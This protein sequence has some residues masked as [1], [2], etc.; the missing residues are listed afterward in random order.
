[1]INGGD[2]LSAISIA[3]MRPVRNLASL[4]AIEH[5]GITTG[6]FPFSFSLLFAR[7]TQDHDD[8]SKTGCLGS[9]GLE[10][11]EKEMLAETV[12]LFRLT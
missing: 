6:T 8:E 11:I 7:L 5:F 2:C 3:V 9:G 1:M 12:F 4:A 10:R